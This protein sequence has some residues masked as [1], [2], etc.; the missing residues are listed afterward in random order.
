MGYHDDLAGYE[1][2]F[3][4]VGDGWFGSVDDDDDSTWLACF[5]ASGNDFEG[6]Q[7]ATD[8]GDQR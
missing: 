3:H 8:D 1:S 4:L 5:R 2:R 7:R 6:G